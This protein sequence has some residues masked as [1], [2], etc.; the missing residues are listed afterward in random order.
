MLEGAGTCR[1]AR[2]VRFLAPAALAAL[3]VA[4]IVIVVISTGAAGR[5]PRRAESAH[6]S[7]RSVPPYWTVRPGDTLAQIS[8]KTGLTIAQLEAFNL[9][10][11]PLALIPGQRLNLWRHP[12]APRPKAPGPRW[13]T[14]RP[15][16]SL[17]SI[18]VKTGI[19]LATLEHLN[20]RLAP[21]TLQ[22]GDRVRLRP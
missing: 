20:P 3:V 4:I 7:V 13:W 5:R 14:V 2:I 12:P 19:N 16:E 22:P 18:A 11:D 21:A 6:V 10:T 1:P 9:N 15:G 8:Q 17:G